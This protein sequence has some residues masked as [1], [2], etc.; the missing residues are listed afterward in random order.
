[1]DILSEVGRRALESAGAEADPTSLGA[2]E[3]LRR[4]FP[5]ELAAQALTQ[6]SLRRRA[7]GKLPHASRMFLTSDGLQ[8]AT[9]P[10]VAAWRARIFAAAGVQEVWDLGCG[11]GADAMAF[12]AAGL[13]VQGVEAD[14]T[15]AAFATMNLALVGGPP[16]VHARAEDVEV[17]A[18]AGVF[19]DPARRTARGRTWDVGD[20]APPWSLVEEYLAGERFCCVKLGPGLPKQLI[21]DGVAATWVSEADQVVEASLWNRLP[22]GPA[23]VV[24]SGPADEPSVLRRPDGFRELRV[25]DVGRYLLEPD[26]AVIRADLVTQIA[27][28]RELWL[29]D[30]QIAYLSCDEAFDTPFA[31]VFE[32]ADVLPFDVK[33]LRRHVRQAGLGTLEIKCRG[34]DVDPASLRR[35]LQPEGRGSA[36]LILS[37]T[38]KGA[39]AVV[40]HRVQ[41]K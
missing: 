8:Q 14:A 29:L 19:L 1:M 27:P 5:P 26:N 15:T 4:T 23:A 24:F 25:A 37:R 3:R 34:V 17:P 6:V 21:P 32:V 11:L 33:A 16:V 12:A 30:H 40:A 18:G 20:F 38:P 36:T 35:T 22:P 9:R 7:A 28:G 2:A 31:D 13:R 39:V 41:P 10:R